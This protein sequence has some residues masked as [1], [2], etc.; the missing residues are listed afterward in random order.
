[1]IVE[2]LSDLMTKRGM[3]SEELAGRLD[4]STRVISR[5]AKGDYQ[6]L[7]KTTLNALCRELDCTPGDL[8]EYVPD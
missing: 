1:M 5:I 6:A 8:L 2:R 3:T 7:R 4:M